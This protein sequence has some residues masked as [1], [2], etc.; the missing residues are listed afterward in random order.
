[1]DAV[2]FDWDGTLVDSLDGFYR[3]NVAV[4][5]TYGLPFDRERYRLTYA[6]D[7]RVMYTRLGIPADRL[8]EANAVWHREFEGGDGVVA[9][10]GV[11]DALRRL[12]DA[13]L[14]LGLVTAGRRNLV[15]SQLERLGLAA[16]LPVR[17][18]GDDLPVHKPDPA[19]IRR[20]LVEL[21]LDARPDAV[22]Y[23]GD[24]PDDMRMAVAAGVPGVGIVSILGDDDALVA[25]GAA[26]V[27][28]SVADWVDTALGRTAPGPA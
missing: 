17:V 11:H 20:A 5:R 26:E 9:F 22:R 3:A 28:Q 13:G 1:M 27:A 23:L 8:D 14:R 6:P 12:D 7:W 2:V 24:A 19:P 21:G 4:M 18:F 16:L 10:A 15:E 25:A